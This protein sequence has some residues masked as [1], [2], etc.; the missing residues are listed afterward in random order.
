MSERTCQWCDSD[1]PETM[2]SDEVRVGKIVQGSY[3]VVDLCSMECL[4]EWAMTPW[5][6]LRKWGPSGKAPL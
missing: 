2:T 3:T 4:R 1:L 5:G 6:P